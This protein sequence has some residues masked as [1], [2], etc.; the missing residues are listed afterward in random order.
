MALRH[1]RKRRE[2]I[3]YWGQHRFYEVLHYYTQSRPQSSGESY[4]IG[5]MLAPL[6]LRCTGFPRSYTEVG[7]NTKA[8]GL[9]FFGPELDKDESIERIS[10]RI[11]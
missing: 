10:A 7:R 5:D 6:C 3:L 9:L 4:A 8:E 1:G 11:L 2:S